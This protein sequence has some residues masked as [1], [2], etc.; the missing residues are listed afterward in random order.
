M[1]EEQGCYLVL[2]CKERVGVWELDYILKRAAGISKQRNCS[3]IKLCE[4]KYGCCECS[5]WQQALCVRFTQ[6]PRQ[7][8]YFH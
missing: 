2:Y 3:C 5:F 4:L 8:I 7:H 6:K 1:F